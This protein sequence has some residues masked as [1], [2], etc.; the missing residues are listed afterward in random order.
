MGHKLQPD[1][2]ADVVCVGAV[3]PVPAPDRPEEW[4]VPFDER[5]PRL[6][7]AAPG[8]HHQVSDR[9]VLHIRVASAVMI[10]FSFSQSRTSLNRDALRSANSAR[11]AT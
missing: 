4:G 3:Q 7:V 10:L 8:A 5:T 1:A 6:L 11:L 2:L 9:R